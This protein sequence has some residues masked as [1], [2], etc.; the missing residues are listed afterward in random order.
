[1]E[2]RFEVKLDP[3]VKAA[4]VA[5]QTQ[6]ELSM[7]AYANMNESFT[8]LGEVRTIRK[9]LTEAAARLKP[10]AKKKKL[11]EA[12]NARVAAFDEA[13]FARLNQQ[14]GQILD[15]LQDVDDGPTS[16]VAATL[17]EKSKALSDLMAAWPRAQSAAKQA[18][19]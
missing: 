5:M 8:V 16:Q 1:M 18:L 19:R 11:L 10:A 17:E 9:L 3:R 15:A 7:R 13:G 6:F 4:S 14:M 2:Q 12:E